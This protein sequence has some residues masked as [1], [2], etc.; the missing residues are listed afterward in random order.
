MNSEIR[1]SHLTK[2]YKNGVTALNDV[3]FTV[4]DGIFG[5]LGHNG[6][7]KS[8]LM[9]AVVTILKPSGGKISVCGYDTQKEGGEVRSRI[10]YLPQELLMYP[11]LS[12]FDFVSYMA[13]LKGVCGDAP[14]R[15]VLR[16]VEMERCAGQKIGQ[17]SGGMRRR[18]A[19]AQA[20]VGHP[21]VLVLDEP[22]AGLDPEERERFHGVISRLAG[23]GRTVIFSTH[24]VDDVY[25]L[26]RELAVIKNGRLV[27]AGTADAVPDTLGAAYVRH[28]GDVYE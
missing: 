1:I 9:K 13:R 28:R 3:S 2:Q 10:G 23:E 26:C 14:V 25:R 8:T 5:L 11:Q 20:L 6:A 18:V 24:I 12:A 15:E 27:Y 17:L 22:T 16:L 4:R 7:G 21:R 19:I